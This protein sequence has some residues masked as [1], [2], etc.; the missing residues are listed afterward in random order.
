[1]KENAG[2]YNQVIKLHGILVFYYC[3]TH[4]PKTQWLKNAYIYS[5]TVCKGWKYGHGFDAC[6][7]LGVSQGVAV[8]LWAGLWAELWP[9]T[10]LYEGRICLQAY[11]RGCWQDFVSC[12][13]LDLGPQFL[14]AVAWRPP[15]VP[16][17]MGLSIEQLATQ[18]LTAQSA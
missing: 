5:L 16:Y 7:W 18:H 12:K 6:L 11:S 10:E 1:M 2:S 15:S 9:H 13:L 4:C 3:I 14:L 17:H 8:K